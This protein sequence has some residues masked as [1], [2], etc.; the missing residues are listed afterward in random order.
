[1]PTADDQ[2]MT[3]PVSPIGLSNSATG[4]SNCITRC[5]IE[6]ALEQLRAPVSDRRGRLEKGQRRSRETV[7]R[8]LGVLHALLE[9]ARRIL[10]DSHVAMLNPAT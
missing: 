3:A 2:G 9:K 7:R 5:E 6:R 4:M 8:Y 1:M 10:K